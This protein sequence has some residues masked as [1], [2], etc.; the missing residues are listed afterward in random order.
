VRG[1]HQRVLP[2]SPALLSQLKH[3]CVT[4]DDLAW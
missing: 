2:L 1:W 4:A 3:A